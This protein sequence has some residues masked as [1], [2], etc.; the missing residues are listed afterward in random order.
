[1]PGLGQW[2]FKLPECSPAPATPCGF[3]GEHMTHAWRYFRLWLA[4]ARF[5]MVRELAFRTNFLVKMFV[6]IL[7]L[8]ILIAFYCTIFAKTS[9][10]ADWDQYQYLF[11]MG[12]YFAL[13]GLLETLFLENCNEFADLVR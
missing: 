2:Q 10:V 6:E 13:G 3:F 8:S 5:S 9:V 1:M 4:L 7:W 12:F 11:F